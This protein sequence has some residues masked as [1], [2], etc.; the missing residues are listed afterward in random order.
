MKTRLFLYLSGCVLIPGLISCSKDNNEHTWSLG[1]VAIQVPTSPS[2]PDSLVSAGALT[3]SRRLSSKSKMVFLDK[4]AMEA[5]R[6]DIIT[7]CLSEEKSYTRTV[8]LR[9]SAQIQIDHLLP[10]DL[11]RSAGLTRL[12]KANCRLELKATH[13]HGSTH[14]FAL[15]DLR[16][17]I[18]AHQ[19][20]ERYELFDYVTN[21]LLLSTCDVSACGAST[22]AAAS[23]TKDEAEIVAIDT[24]KLSGPEASMSAR[25]RA[26]DYSLICENF[27]NH[28]RLSPTID[29]DDQ[30]R[31]LLKELF[32]GPLM[33]AAGESISVLS[34]P[35]HLAAIQT[36]SLI[37]RETSREGAILDRL[38]ELNYAPSLEVNFHAPKIEVSI[39]PRLE[40]VT[41]ESYKTQEVF[42]LKFH[43]PRTAPVKIR[44]SE[45]PRSIALQH[46]FLFM[47]LSAGNWYTEPLQIEVDGNVPKWG[48]GEVI[49]IIIP[50]KK[51]STL[52]LR[53]K[54]SRE[55]EIH[56]FDNTVVPTFSRYTRGFAYKLEK[57]I[58][59]EMF[60]SLD[61][62]M[63]SG[64]F[65]STVI[66]EKNDYAINDTKNTGLLTEGF[67]S[68][69]LW[70]KRQPEL[71]FKY[72]D[73]TASVD[74]PY[75]EGCA[76]PKGL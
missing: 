45:L 15:N 42:A 60:D 50:A 59:V 28:R 39:E 25:P 46:H 13:P 63:E 4:E 68:R 35:R 41:T 71:T 10:N 26:V 19:P 18:P 65:A 12:K 73:I 74:R 37:A 7:R 44:I 29:V 43:N 21:S 66:Y 57:N 23:A 27:E 72:I 9:P 22:G 54:S 38:P 20:N 48:L 8:S 69:T 55:C 30:A 36:C 75:P 24:K 62:N 14:R 70:R 16:F 58:K 67:I 56:H 6:F 51:I 1:R 76:T 64:R 53:L 40:S 17:D 52:T 33:T 3:G 11:F 5:D 47:F 2:S 31:G 34:D 32:V 49:D 61:I